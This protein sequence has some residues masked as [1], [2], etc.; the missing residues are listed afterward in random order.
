AIEI[1]EESSLDRVES[2]KGAGP[3]WYGCI[4]ED[5]VPQF[6]FEVEKD[7]ELVG[8]ID[9]LATNMQRIDIVDPE[10]L[11]AD[12]ELECGA[13][14][15]V[16]GENLDFLPSAMGEQGDVLEITRQK[17][18]KLLHPGDEVRYSGYPDEP[19]SVIVITRASQTIAVQQAR[20]TEQGGYVLDRSNSCSSAFDVEPSDELPDVAEVVCEKDGVRI[21]TPQVRPQRDGVHIHIENASGRDAAF[22]FESGGRDAS[23]TLVLP[24]A[25]GSEEVGCV[26]GFEDAGK[27]R[28]ERLH[29][30]DPEG[31]YVTAGAECPGGI[32]GSSGGL[33]TP[34]ARG[35]RGDP[36]QLTRERFADQIKPGDEVLRAGY[37]DDPEPVVAIVRGGRTMLT[38]EF[39]PDG[40]D[41]WFL[42]A[43]NACADF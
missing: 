34:D 12:A 40:E 1:I 38:Q 35:E 31:L 16:I 27:I 4:A 2:S 3:R 13:S 26:I 33:L 36:V 14:S 8:N 7:S 19:G 11:Y 30:V 41:R 28:K 42:D 37:P 15:D 23:G 24:I 21:V 22:V 29:V 17:W 32:V 25:P 6:I 39:L 20:S 18:S 9:S 43:Y 10:H 5:V